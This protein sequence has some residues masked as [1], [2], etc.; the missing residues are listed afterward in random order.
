[1][2]EAIKEQITISDKL[3]PIKIMRSKA[4]IRDA[5]FM[6]G[7][8]RPRSL[9]IA[10][11]MGKE[12]D[13]NMLRMQMKFDS[14]CGLLPDYSLCKNEINVGF[15]WNGLPIL[16]Q[17]TF[18][19]GITAS[20]FVSILDGKTHHY[21]IPV[22][23]QNS[24]KE[25]SL[26]GKTGFCFVYRLEMLRI[27]NEAMSNNTQRATLVYYIENDQVTHAIKVEVDDAG[28]IYFFVRYDSV[29]YSV[30]T[31]DAMLTPTAQSDYFAPDY[32][33][34]DYDTTPDLDNIQPDPPY[35]YSDIAFSFNFT[36]HALKIYKNGV[37]IST[38]TSLT[39]VPAGAPVFPPGFADPPPPPVQPLPYVVPLTQVYNQTVQ[40]AAVKMHAVTTT[41]QDSIYAVAVG[42]DYTTPIDIVYS[43]PTGVPFKPPAPP[44]DNRIPD[45][46]KRDNYDLLYTT[47]LVS[48]D[49]FAV[50]PSTS[51]IEIGGDSGTLAVALNILSTST[52]AGAALLGQVIHRVSFATGPNP[53]PTTGLNCIIWDHTGKDVFRFP[54]QTRQ[55][56]DHWANGNFF[57]INNNVTMKQNY[58]I[59]FASF[60]TETNLKM[61]T[62][63][64]KDS[65]ID[66]ADLDDDNEVGNTPYEDWNYDS[67]SGELAISLWKKKA[68]PVVFLN[69]IGIGVE[70][71]QTLGSIDLPSSGES[72][73]ELG[74]DDDQYT[75]CGLTVINT[76][77]GMGK[78]IIGSAITIAR[79]YLRR[80]GTVAGKYY[81]KMWDA[82]GIEVLTFASSV[83]QE[84][85]NELF[86]K[87]GGVSNSN[88]LITQKNFII[89]I[90]YTEGD[91]GDSLEMAVSADVNDPSI[92]M[93]LKN[94]N[95]NWFT[96]ELFDPCCEIVGGTVGAPTDSNTNLLAIEGISGYILYQNSST[97]LVSAFNALT[98]TERLS[99]VSTILSIPFDTVMFSDATIQPFTGFVPTPPTG[100][101]G[102]SREKLTNTLVPLTSAPS[103]LSDNVLVPTFPHAWVTNFGDHTIEKTPLLKIK[104]KIGPLTV[105]PTGDFTDLGGIDSE[106]NSNAILQKN[107]SQND[108][109]TLQIVETS[110]GL[111]A[112]LNTKIVTAAQFYLKGANSPKGQIYCRIWNASGQALVTLGQFDSSQLTGSYLEV[113]FINTQNTVQM[114][115]GH[116]IGLEYSEG[117]SS[118]QVL[119]Q[120]NSDPDDESVIQSNR[121]YQD[122]DF[123]TNESFQPK[124]HFYGG[125][126]GTPPNPDTPDPTPTGDPTVQ[127][128]QI[129][130]SNKPG[131]ISGVAQRF[132]AG[133]PM[134]GTIPSLIEF[135][136]YRTA[137]TTGVL[138]IEHVDSNMTRRATLA[139]YD[140]ATLPTSQPSATTFNLVWQDTNYGLPIFDNDAIVVRVV[141]VN[142]D[143]VLIMDN[144]GNNSN[145][146]NYDGVRSYMAYF[147]NNDSKWNTN[148]TDLD[149]AGKIFKG[150]ESFYPYIAL[151]NLRKRVGVKAVVAESKLVGK[152]PTKVIAS[153]KKINNPPDGLLFC[154]IRANDGSLKANIAVIDTTSI[155]STDTPLTFINTQNAVAM[156]AGDTISIEYDLGTATDYIVISINTRTQVETEIPR[157]ILA[158]T[159]STNINSSN[160]LYNKELSA[161]IYT[162]GRQD[163]T[164]RP[165]RGIKLNTNSMLI[166]KVIT[167]VR[168]RLMATGLFTS[169]NSF[170]RAKI[171][172]GS[173]KAT[174]KVIATLDAA[175]VSNSFH[176]EYYFLNY[177]NTYQMQAGDYVA[178]EANFGNG[179]DHYITMQ[180]S[181][182]DIVD[183]QNTIMFEYNGR[184]YVDVPGVDLSGELYTG[185]NTVT[186][187]PITITPPTPFHYGHEWIIAAASP[188]DSNAVSDPLLLS[189]KLNSFARNISKEFRLY[190]AD[191]TQVQIENYFDNRFSIS[192]IPYGKIE[193]VGHDITG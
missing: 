29:N 138:T 117:D 58:K 162:G 88:I 24:I 140:V 18:D 91:D 186:P 32:N 155:G 10:Y 173:D 55:P 146:N 72:F 157:T 79:F 109:V 9:G 119:V 5:G 6:S 174:M 105:A 147:T 136:A 23:M 107:T 87:M 84:L 34:A 177:T 12:P 100:Y 70:N 99:K 89:G 171:I 25:M 61:Q 133:S 172:R 169:G 151:N 127:F 118:D 92:V 64:E 189:P 31:V 83:A 176:V 121:K 152:T 153:G 50:D 120:R 2:E 115:S 114:V 3:S 175:S 156:A 57:D 103:L 154:R 190:S 113:T 81:H 4:T 180:T 102:T 14:V 145:E 65:T 40:T 30:K 95:G 184:N 129:P 159:L 56:F 33:P 148:R 16:R 106:A 116:R 163:L 52:G 66:I 43:V 19:D 188:P 78:S 63:G 46:T 37:E 74:Q 179:A 94:K 108:I 7:Y 41:P 59:G 82:N 130:L 126:G 28:Y 112:A 144:V 48:S 137:S 11:Y 191:L 131:G 96:N 122:D 125:Q 101:T 35:E 193:V 62:V 181:Q 73:F 8:T 60:D 134:V 86:S 104:D 170:I 69:D 166:G 93:S 123:R 17:G 54:P 164:A 22:N 168:V 71:P 53:D 39:L 128:P 165:M 158:E 97:Q 67:G 178:I 185:G 160:P 142:A 15:M 45:W 26:S 150:G 85:D 132:L 21:R 90:E 13:G 20:D 51:G 75:R 149:L 111:G 77:D 124:C 42:D 1:M 49:P 167:E 183:G 110:S 161:F 182:T 76:L 141:G 47:R 187:D 68:V 38:T 27:D 98:S 135:Q 139:N 80:K 44:P 192:P 36:T 143:P